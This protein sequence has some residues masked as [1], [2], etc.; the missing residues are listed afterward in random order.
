VEMPASGPKAVENAEAAQRST[1]AVELDYGT[2][3]KSLMENG[4]NMLWL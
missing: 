2:S 4:D 3:V 1:V